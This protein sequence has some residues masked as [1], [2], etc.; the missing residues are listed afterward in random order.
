MTY[1]KI[2]QNI[3]N[4]YINSSHIVKCSIDIKKCRDFSQDYLDYSIFNQLQ[5]MCPDVSQCVPA[6]G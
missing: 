1:H 5:A 2:S 4:T 6:A 3:S